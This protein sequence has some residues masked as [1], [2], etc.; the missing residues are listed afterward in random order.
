MP[1]MDVD[2]KILGLTRKLILCPRKSYTLPKKISYP[3][4]FF[5]FPGFNPRTI[6]NLTQK[7]LS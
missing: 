5:L 6:P 2:Q 4:M 3:R 1:R 7:K